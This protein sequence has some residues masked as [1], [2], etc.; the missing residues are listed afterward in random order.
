MENKSL[1]YTCIF[2]GGAIRGM[3]YVGALRAMEEIGIKVKTYAGSSVGSIFAALIAVGYNSEELKKWFLSIN[4][5]LFRDIHFGFGKALALS[6]GGVFLEVIREAIEKK[7]YGDKYQKGKNPPVK[8]SD[9]EKNLVII[10]TD[11]K[12]FK[13]CEF[14]KFTTPDYEIA[15]AVRISSAMPGLMEPVPYKNTVLVDGDLQK[16]WPLWRLSKSLCAEE[17]RILEFRLEGDYDVKDKNPINFI[18]TIYSCITSL[19]T[20]FIVETYGQRDKFDYIII[21]TGVVIVVDFNLSEEKRLELMDVGYNT[22]K[23]YFENDI[24]DKKENI[25]KLYRELSKHLKQIEKYLNANKI[26]HTENELGQLF[27]SMYDAKKYV[28]TNFLTK[29]ERFKDDFYQNERPAGLFGFKHVENDK[30][31][32]AEL[33]RLNIEI[34]EKIM[35][36]EKF[37]FKL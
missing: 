21:N 9:L 20:D 29:I 17:G 15:S 31:L 25:L 4:Y 32:K 22:T 33:L 19:A 5:E 34:D 2:G 8:F 11:L 18:N 1:E 7:F 12:N 3:S 16:S 13:P 30:Y 28:D 6:K 14:S 24:F 10:T 27:I 23:D 26:R 36:L 37:I 35:E